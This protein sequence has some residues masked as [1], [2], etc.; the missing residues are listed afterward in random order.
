VSGVT[1]SLHWD[2]SEFSVSG[3]ALTVCTLRA[4]EYAAQGEVSG[5][6]GVR[7]MACACDAEG[8]QLDFTSA[9]GGR[10]SLSST[11]SIY[12]VKVLALKDSKQIFEP[13]LCR[14]LF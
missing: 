6:S 2:G 5:G 9:A 10:F 14:I 3:D 8:K 13:F 11:S 1:F 12:M 4:G 7:Y